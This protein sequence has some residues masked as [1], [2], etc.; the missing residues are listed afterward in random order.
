MCFL[1][2][3][4][5]L[6]LCK[7]ALLSFFIRFSSIVTFYSNISKLSVE[8]CV[9]SF[10]LQVIRALKSDARLANNNLPADIQKLRCRVHYEALRF[11]P[12]IEALGKVCCD[13]QVELVESAVPASLYAVDSI[14]LQI[15]WKAA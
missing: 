9:N 2:V 13:T 15:V 4:V 3:N 11:A 12:S 14:H 8:D 10:V 5:V 1:D 7:E 6:L